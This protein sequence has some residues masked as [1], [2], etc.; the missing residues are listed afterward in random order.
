MPSLKRY[1]LLGCAA[2]VTFSFKVIAFF[3]YLLLCGF[4]KGRQTGWLTYYCRL[5]TAFFKKK[6][7]AKAVLKNWLP[8]GTTSLSIK[9]T[10]TQSN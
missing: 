7:T 1:N 8:Y 4:L 3:V 10:K 6:L 5:L 2:K 9:G